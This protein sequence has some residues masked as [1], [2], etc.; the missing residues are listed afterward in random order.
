MRRKKIRKQRVVLRRKRRDELKVHA[1]SVIYRSMAAVLA[2]GFVLGM[3][4]HGDAYLYRFLQAHTPLISL[5]APQALMSVPFDNELPRRKV[6]LWIPGVGARVEARLK[7]RYSQIK[8]VQFQRLPAQNRI[9]VIIEPR[10]PIVRW[11]D[12]GMDGEGVIFAMPPGAWSQLPRAN[13]TATIPK[14][15]LGRWFAELGQIPEFWNEVAA[16]RDDRHGNIIFDLK[17]GAQVTWGGPDFRGSRTKASTLCSVLKDA[18]EHL[19]GMAAADLR[20][21]D[22]GRIIVRPKTVRS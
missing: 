22:E 13:V 17:T 5:K 3:L 18:H 20:F 11:N 1:R 21:F 4:T 2:A 7:V 12:S 9:V 16:I 14:D 15:L 8:E 19:G 6:L 10:K